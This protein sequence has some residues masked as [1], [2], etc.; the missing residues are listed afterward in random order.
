MQLFL[1]ALTL[2]GFFGKSWWVFDIASHF[3]PQYFLLLGLGAL[4]GFW[5]KRRRSSV[6]FILVAMLNL[7]L[8]LPYYSSQT[9]ISKTGAVFRAMNLNLNV[10]NLAFDKVHKLVDSARP[11]V[12]MLEE[13]SPFWV[14]KAGQVFSRY[15]YFKTFAR[16]D[17]FGIGVFSKI[18]LKKVDVF[19]MNGDIPVLVARLDLNGHTLSL[20]GTHLKP[21]FNAAFS[22]DRNDGL[23]DLANLIISTKGTKMVMGDFNLTPWSPYFQD[24]IAKT[25][26]NDSQKGIG[27]QP[28]WPTSMPLFWIPLDH[29]FVT[30]D[31][32]IHARNI[33]PNVDSDHYP[34]IVDFSLNMDKVN[35][36]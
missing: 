3:R 5:G 33:G 12:I 18:P 32:N 30:K 2:M 28:S 15:P 26:L 31:I 14:R 17:A 29:C 27:I 34:V 23:E 20:I 10:A 19:T 6:F 1:V 7:W 11:D 25:G 4:V 36:S 21:P 35:A 9:A 8:I 13:L 16:E 22:K 24:F